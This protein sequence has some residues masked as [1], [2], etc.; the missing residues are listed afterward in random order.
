M[1]PDTSYRADV[2]GLRALAVVLVI[3]FHIHTPWVQGGYIGVDVFFVISGYVITRGTA[4]AITEGRFRLTTFYLRRCRRLLPALI[5]V[6]C[7]A[8]PV[9]WYLLHPTAFGDFSG[10]A[11]AS[12]LFVSNILYSFTDPYLVDQSWLNP[13]IHTW[14]LGVEAQFYLVFPVILMLTLRKRNLAALLAISILSL[15]SFV[16]A[17]VLT[18]ISKEASFYLPVTRFW[19]FGVGAILALSERYRSQKYQVLPWLLPALSLLILLSSANLFTEATYHPGPM[20]LFPVAATALLIWGGH[21]PNFVSRALSLA[22][23]VSIG[24]ASYSIYLWH[25]PIL[26]FLRDAL[27]SEPSLLTLV[28]C[29]PALLILSYFS[30]HFIEKPIREARQ[31][32]GGFDL[33]RWAAP[34]LIMLVACGLGMWTQYSRLASTSSALLYEPKRGIAQINGTPCLINDLNDICIIGD[35][36][37]TPTVAILGD[38]HAHTLTQ[39][40]QERLAEEHVSAFVYILAGCPF[41]EQVRRIG[42]PRDC[43][44]FIEEVLDRLAD[45]TVQSVIISDYRSAYISGMSE[46]AAVPS[47]SLAVYPLEPVDGHRARLEAV[48][49][50]QRQTI[51]R[52]LGMG[53][54]VTLILPVPDAP[55]RVPAEIRNRY[56]SNSLPYRYPV[57]SY[58]TRSSTVLALAQDYAENPQ[59]RAIFPHKVFCRDDGFCETHGQ[60]QVYYTDSNHLS[61][62]GADWLIDAAER[63]LLWSMNGGSN[64]VDR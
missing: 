14:S 8:S 26:A 12:L 32:V 11:A 54:N 24:G 20:T 34:T 25:Q 29:S 61:A 50:L 58:L 57:Q 56:S 53:L 4:P 9:A 33:G 60:D 62:E 19:E 27:N 43:P 38:S 41:I 45:S 51:D 52:L 23:L 1:P 59:F 39:S 55:G 49:R 36:D 35:Q 64:F 16:L 40:I 2:D 5:L 48:D 21:R 7:A 30:L 22:P 10:N 47:E 18:G 17:V 3:L 31:P 42:Y 63:D 37:V 44:R 15:V 6:L 46:A 28:L 13:L